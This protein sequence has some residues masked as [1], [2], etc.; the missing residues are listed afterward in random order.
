M[1]PKAPPPPR[2]PRPVPKR[3]RVPRRPGP[4]KKPRGKPWAKGQSGNPLG[5]PPLPP[6]TREAFQA[7]LPEALGAL[8]D[9]VQEPEH[10]RQEQAAEYVVN[11]ALGTPRQ[12]MALTGP[13]GEP[14]Q[15]GG[16]LS[17]TVSFCTTPLSLGRAEVTHIGPDGK[18][19]EVEPPMRDDQVEASPP[20]LP[21]EG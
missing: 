8:R 1:S 4:K 6:G 14:L 3:S 18:P 2:P 12:S 11:Q 15:P 7:M 20:Q 21:K 17:I 5:R 16:P 19:V 13:N 9:I 10:P